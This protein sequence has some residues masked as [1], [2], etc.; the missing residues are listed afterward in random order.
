L[1]ANVENFGDVGVETSS[2][3]YNF[4]VERYSEEAFAVSTADSI[5]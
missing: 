1:K 4:V 2:R 5:S 3:Q